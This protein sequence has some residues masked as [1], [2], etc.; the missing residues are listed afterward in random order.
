MA[1]PALRR[2][3]RGLCSVLSCLPSRT[4]SSCSLASAE[5][6]PL[7]GNVNLL[8]EETSGSA[9][10]AECTQC[11]LGPHIGTPDT[12]VPGSHR[13]EQRRTHPRVLRLGLGRRPG[14]TMRSEEWWRVLTQSCGLLHHSGRQK[15]P[16]EGKLRDTCGQRDKMCEV[17]LLLL[18]SFY[19]CFLVLGSKPETEHIAS[20]LP[21]SY[22][23]QF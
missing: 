5:R 16:R 15:L 21:L 10:G 11:P 18:F 4:F 17:L 6:L 7:S 9:L 3:G 1:N 20:V 23:P 8:T 22:I 2:P 19:F 14:L 13:K 12:H